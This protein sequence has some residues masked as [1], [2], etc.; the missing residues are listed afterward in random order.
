MTSEYSVLTQIKEVCK[1]NRISKAQLL[2]VLML[3]HMTKSTD[4][5]CMCISEYAD[6]TGVVL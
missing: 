4:S 1:H 6:E 3:E 5:V 2:K